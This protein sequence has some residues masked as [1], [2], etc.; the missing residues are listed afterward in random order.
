[1]KIDRSVVSSF[2]SVPP[3]LVPRLPLPRLNSLRA[4]HRLLRCTAHT[5]CI[6]D[7]LVCACVRA[8]ARS[9][10][11]FKAGCVYVWVQEFVVCEL[12]GVC[13]ELYERVYIYLCGFTLHTMCKVNARALMKPTERMRRLYGYTMM[14]FIP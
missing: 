11:R 12:V 10:M 3:S 13:L 9:Y 7:Y 6:L 5:D 14:T 2:L 4:V 1:M 8:P